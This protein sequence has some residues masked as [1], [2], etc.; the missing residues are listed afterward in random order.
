VISY[1]ISEKV[2]KSAQVA[3]R[4]VSTGLAALRRGTLA[5]LSQQ[6]D[7]SPETAARENAAPET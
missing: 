7:A 1:T 2:P 6:I 4:A 3:F 5:G